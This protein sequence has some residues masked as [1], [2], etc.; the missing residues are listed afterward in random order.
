MFIFKKFH[1]PLTNP[2]PI[3]SRFRSK[4]FIPIFVDQVLRFLE[5]NPWGLRDSLSG[6]NLFIGNGSVL[7]TLLVVCHHLI[8]VA[9]QRCSAIG[10][11]QLDIPMFQRL[12]FSE[13]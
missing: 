7:V 1:P 4:L 3:L 10:I 9:A 6:W 2:V 5:N 13:L 11:K 12:V 8:I